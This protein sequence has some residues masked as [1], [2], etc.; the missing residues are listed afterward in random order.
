MLHSQQGGMAMIEKETRTTLRL[1]PDLKDK[2]TK[3]AK[4]ENRSLHN[5]I[6][7]ILQNHAKDK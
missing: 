2:L 1:P 5:L 3:E 4:A 6:I 7:T